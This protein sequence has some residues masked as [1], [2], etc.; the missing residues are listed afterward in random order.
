VGVPKRIKKRLADMR[1][2]PANVGFSDARAVAE[3]YFDKPRKSG[4]SHYVFKMPWA[5]DPRVNLQDEGHGAKAYQ[6]RQLLAAV[7]R[8]DHERAQTK[9]E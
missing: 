8:Y 1:A 4:S 7:D 6:V 9:D 3:Y 2:N 5:G